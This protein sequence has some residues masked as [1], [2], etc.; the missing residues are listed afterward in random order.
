MS[1]RKKAG[2]NAPASFYE[3]KS[4]F[5]AAEVGRIKVFA[6]FFQKAG[7]I[8]RVAVSAGG[9]AFCYDRAPAAVKALLVAFFHALYAVAVGIVEFFGV[10]V[11]DIACRSSFALGFWDRL[12][13]V[14]VGYF[15][16]N[17]GAGAL[18]F[19]F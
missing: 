14:G 12:G 10:A 9:I 2:V 3:I 8:L 6:R 15:R 18:R 17:G 1:I 5:K 13:A 16:G 4:V 7:A 11:E 19:A